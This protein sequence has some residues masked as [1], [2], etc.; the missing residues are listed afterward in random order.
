MQKSF[1]SARLSAMTVVLTQCLA[2]LPS[3]QDYQGIEDSSM[4]SHFF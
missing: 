4:S 3:N 1:I 2:H